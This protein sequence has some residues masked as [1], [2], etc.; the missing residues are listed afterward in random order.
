MSGSLTR[1]RCR[2]SG[3]KFGRPANRTAPVSDRLSPTRSTPWLG[4]PITSPAK[5]SS[6]SSRSLA[7]NMMG[8]FTDNCLPVF[9]MRTAMV[10][11]L[12]T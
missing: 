4:M 3:A 11:F 8:A 2:I 1:T 5:A 10:H 9:W 7:K 12:P 6:A